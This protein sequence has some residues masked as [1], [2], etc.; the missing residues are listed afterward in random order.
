MSIISDL[1]SKKIWVENL[2]EWIQRQNPLLDIYEKQVK[3][4][5]FQITQSGKQAD[6]D[7]FTRDIAK[8][9]NKMQ[10]IRN[11]ISKA[12]NLKISIEKHIKTLELTI[13][14]T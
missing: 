13:R 9:E 2:D 4:L 14:A 6:I 3:T 1:A 10:Q 12:K 11:E 8:L 5:E 7:R